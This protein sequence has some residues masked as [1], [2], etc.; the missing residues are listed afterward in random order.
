MR[1]SLSLLYLMAVISILS[2]I[3]DIPQDVLSHRNT[4]VKKVKS[5]EV[6]VLLIITQILLLHTT[7]FYLVIWN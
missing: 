4:V 1:Y 6:N 7:L 2:V 3:N 5:K